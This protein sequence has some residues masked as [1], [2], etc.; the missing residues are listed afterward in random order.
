[1]QLEAETTTRT[2]IEETCDKSCCI[3]IYKGKNCIFCEAA[4]EVL[5]ETLNLYGLT[6]TAIQEID[7]D[8]PD[9]VYASDIVGLPS[10]RI[11]KELFT[12]LPDK[13]QIGTAIVRNF[14]KS[15]L[16]EDC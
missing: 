9:S 15:C 5:N 11:C 2:N 10:I 13:H 8:N 1:M 3:K 12:G 7:V 14:M 16:I 6:E 4:R